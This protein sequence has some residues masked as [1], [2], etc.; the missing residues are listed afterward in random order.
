MRAFQTFVLFAAAIFTFYSGSH[1]EGVI[2]LCAGLLSE[3]VGQ[4]ERMNRR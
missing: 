4:L 3:A 1:L 2:W